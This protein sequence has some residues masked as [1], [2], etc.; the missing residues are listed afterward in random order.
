[1]GGKEQHSKI[2]KNF[3][4]SMGAG[5]GKGLGSAI[6]TQGDGEKKNQSERVQLVSK[7]LQNIEKKKKQATPKSL[8]EK[9]KKDGGGTRTV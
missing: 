2:A 1:M 3:D 7:K 9:Q 5:E 8:S 4:E 6:I